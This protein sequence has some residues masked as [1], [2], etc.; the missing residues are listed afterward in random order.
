MT[1]A[2]IGLWDNAFEQDISEAVKS[3]MNGYV[4]K[5]FNIEKLVDTVVGLCGK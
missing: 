5:P 1:I 2:V 3:G 4:S